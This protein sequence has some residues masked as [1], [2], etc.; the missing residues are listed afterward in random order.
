MSEPDYSVGTFYEES[1]EAVQVNDCADHPRVA[2]HSM[3]TQLGAVF[4]SLKTALGTGERHGAV[5][6]RAIPPPL[7]LKAPNT[8]TASGEKPP[9]GGGMEG[10]RFAGMRLW[11]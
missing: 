9:Q 5:P 4:R 2:F 8:N 7:S 1:V 3:L 11:A 10:C 6:F